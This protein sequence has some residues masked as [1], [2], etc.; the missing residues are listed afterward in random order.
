MTRARGICSIDY[1]DNPIHVIRDQ[2]CS[3]HYQQKKNGRPFT[4]PRVSSLLRDALG[5]KRC[6]DCREWLPEDRFGVASN[7][8]DGRATYCLPCIRIRQRAVLEHRRDQSRAKRYNLSRS[9]FDAMLEAQG[10]RCAICQTNDPGAYHHWCV[11]HDHRCCPGRGQSCGAC[12]RGILCPACNKGIGL[13]GDEAATLLAAAN[14][15]E[16]MSIIRGV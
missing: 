7:S 14:Y 15:L 1:C 12:V 10:G 6:R 4:V 16:R 13:L 5:R 11:D 9:A 2:L 8:L 3:P